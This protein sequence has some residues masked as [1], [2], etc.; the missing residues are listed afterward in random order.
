M[1]KKL[2]IGPQR[3]FCDGVV[4][5]EYV[6]VELPELSLATHEVSGAGVMGT[7][8]VPSRTQIE[9]MELGVSTSGMGAGRARLM[10]PGQHRLEFRATQEVYTP[11]N[12]VQVEGLKIF[13]TGV[14]KSGGGGTLE[15][16]SGV[17][18]DATFE[19]LRYEEYVN[20]EE[21]LIVDKV[22]I[23]YRVLGADHAQDI[24]GYLD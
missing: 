1:R 15:S 21:M 22:N 11:E 8:D 4:I 14:L 19:V 17:E 18:S 5:D 16:A 7:L 2:A 12:G 24:R 10:T 6:S 9:G 13:V 20:G 23:I 3:S